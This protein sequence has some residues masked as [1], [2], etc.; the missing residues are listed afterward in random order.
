MSKYSFALQS[1][2]NVHQLIKLNILAKKAADAQVIEHNTGEDSQHAIENFEKYANSINLRI[3][4]PG[5]YPIIGINEFE[6]QLPI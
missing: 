5:L 3:T 4:W 1:G 2:L 6:F